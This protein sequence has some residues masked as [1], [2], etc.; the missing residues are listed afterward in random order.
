VSEKR[1]QDIMKKWIRRWEEAKIF[2]ADAKPGKPKFFITAAFPYP[3]SPPHI[4]HARTYTITDVYARYLRMRGF[5]VLFP[6]GFHYTG[7]PIVTMAEF[8]E[9]GDKELIDIFVNV[10]G[11]PEEDVEKLKTPLGMAEYFSKLFEENLKKLG[12][13]IDWRRKFRS[14]DPEFQKFV[15]W[16][17]LRLRDKGFITKGTHPVGWCP[18]HNIPVGMHDTKGDVEPEIGEFTV[19]F[20]KIKDEDVFLAAATLRPETILGVTNIWVR[21]DANYV[22]VELAEYK[23]KIVV[24]EKA[25]FKLKFQRKD[26]TVLGKLK[27]EDLVGKRVINPVTEKEVPVLPASFVNPNF[28][29]GVVMSVPAHAPYDYV[30]LKEILKEKELLRNF[31]ISSQDLNPIPLIKVS[32][33]KKLPAAEEVEKLRI[34]SQLDKEKLEKATQNVYSAE[35]KYG[36]MREDIIDLVGS[37]YRDIIAR[38]RGLKVPKAR[39]IVKNALIK[40]LDATIMYELL[41]GPIY[42]R[43]GNEIVVKVL[44]N[45]WFLDYSNKEWKKLAKMALSKM[46]IVPEELRSAFERTIDWLKLRAM[47][48]T[49]GLGTPLPWDK[50]WVIESLSDSTIYMAFYTVINI[51]RKYKV[52]PEKLVPEVWDYVFLGKGDPQEL[53]LKY[54]IPQEFLD[55]A[56]KE[57]TYWYP[58][59][60]RHSGRDLVENHL[61]FMIFH[62]VALFPEKYWPKQIVVNGFILYEGKKMS[63]SLRNI[64]PLSKAIETYGPDGVRTALI[65]GAELEQDLD[66][67]PSLA[68]R[69]S[70]ELENFLDLA[71]K[72]KDVKPLM[73]TPS[74]KMNRWILSRLRRVVEETT[75]DMNSL[76]LRAA[77]HKI[78]FEIKT[79]IN[80]WLERKGFS[81]IN[82]L[83][84]RGDEESKETLRLL[85]EIL[86][87]MLQPFAPFT[88]EEAWEILGNEGFVSLAEWPSPDTLPKDH[89]IELEEEYLKILI[90][91]INEVLK[92]VPNATKA[93]I[94][95]TPKEEYS[96]LLKAIEAVEKRRSSELFQEAIKKY[97][98]ERGI[99]LAQKVFRFV[100][101]LSPLVRELVKEV[102]VLDER[103][104]IAENIDFIVK[105]VGLKSIEVKTAITL[106]E[107]EKMPI[108]LRPAIIIS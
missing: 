87:R 21:P 47:A 16:Q 89:V 108:P 10:Y 56:R 75:S 22:I 105:K 60:S 57:F 40:L 50:S 48:R 12:M 38:I 23:K 71:K 79:D 15:T 31:G 11:V 94:F 62:H 25:A 104:I 39:E 33:F 78:M 26:I 103:R 14:I 102:K 64:V 49:R 97:G 58:L 106:E 91:D 96:L 55:E 88:A 68:L 61:T 34:T 17:Y 73:H 65:Y 30:A 53:S 3:N 4:G 28:A 43:C 36:V 8:V 44:E 24:S 29:T 54:G 32:G 41:N 9:K 81:S 101:S 42:C 67:R 83:V 13:S 18:V 20:F 70:K 99:K 77:F 100:T 19:I 74:N 45:Q 1:F 69:L 107:V 27:G 92:L 76:R 95:V 2:E 35:Y 93:T 82:E 59:D 46:R 6:M 72:V 51:I 66:F 37:K 52:D 98:R 84:K 90:E 5:N 85:V 80:W 86:T 7:T 63:K